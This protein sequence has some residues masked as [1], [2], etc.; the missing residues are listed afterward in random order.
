M[1]RRRKPH[2][3]RNFHRREKKRRSIELLSP[4]V[5]ILGIGMLYPSQNTIFRGHDFKD[6][7]Q[8]FDRIENITLRLC[9]MSLT[10]TRGLLDIRNSHLRAG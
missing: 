9:I 1:G 8:I 4:K 3:K 2:T 7:A 6:F 10:H 5:A